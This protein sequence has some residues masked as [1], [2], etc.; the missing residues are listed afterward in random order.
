MR[1]Q[2]G[3]EAVPKLGYWFALTVTFLVAPAANRAA[4]GL[5]SACR[6]PVHDKQLPPQLLQAQ[7]GPHS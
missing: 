5:P 1:G 3:N 4:D 2:G 6:Q 7:F